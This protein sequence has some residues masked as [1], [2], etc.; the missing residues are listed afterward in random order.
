MKPRAKVRVP[1]RG[2]TGKSENDD[3]ASVWGILASSIREI[4][5]KNSSQ[6]SFEEL[7]RNAYKL[8]LRKQAM[9]LYEKVAD[10]EKDWLYNEVR[11]QV[12]ALITPAL[13]TITD[14]I[15]AT[16]HAN[17]RKAAGERL[18]TKLKEVWEDHQLCMGMITDVLMYMDRVVMQELRNQSI[19][20]TSMFLFRDCVLRADIGE[21]ANATIGSVF[22]NTMLFMILLEREGV[23]IDRALIKHC[24]YLL[25]GLYEDGMEDP[26][27]KLYH[28]TFE[29]AFLEASRK[30]YAAE[31]QRLLTTTDAATFCKRVT[32]RI[33]AE[34][35]LCRQTLSPVTEAKVMEVIDDCLIRHYI[36]EVIRMDDSGVKYMIQNDRLEDLRNVFELIARIDAKKAA[37]TRV[38]Q[39]TVVEYGTAINNAAKELSQNPPAPSTIEPGKK[40]S[41][42]EE[43]PPVLNVQTAAAIKWVDDV[44]KL[45]AKFDRIWEEAFVKDQ[46]LQTSLT[47]S[48]SDFINVNPRGTEYLSLFFDENLRK[49]IKGKTEEEVD[50][51]IENGITLLRYIRDK[52]L[53]ETY[54]KKHLSRRLLMKRSASMDAERQMIA[55]MKMEVG[56][57]F[58]QRLESMFK[59][60]AVSTDLTTNYR[61]YIAQ[62]GDPDIKR[63]ELEMSV[64]TSTMWPMEIMSSY[65]RDGQVQLPCIFPKNVESLK[66]SF[67]RFYLDKHSGRKLWWLPGMGTADIRATF[68][69]PNGKVERHDLNVS[70]YAMVILLL[71]NDMP[72]GESLTFE[73]IQEKTRIPTNELIRNLQSLAVA[74]KTRVLRKEP[75]SKG[76]QP[77]D[78]FSF[79]EQFTSKFT[80]LK[81]GVVSAGGNKVENK[82]ERTDTEKK[83]SEERGN[84]IE[85]AI[86]TENIGSFAVITEA[87]SQLAARF[88]PDVNMVK[89]RI[90][91]LIDR[92][93]LERIT[94]SDPPAYSYVA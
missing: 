85:A 32:G 60:M 53:F 38:V 50:T 34:Q 40:P 37:L 20:D 73:E 13:L 76:V 22:E 3:F 4:H 36:G 90:E 59:D 78:K 54:Y 33:K 44:L 49:G 77:S 45:K 18:L 1:R 55:K 42:A 35:S 61:D 72:S 27:G 80:R 70:T 57:T 58:T 26:S 67:E 75:M 46:A 94:D 23:I 48:F 82:E 86:T 30:Y 52:D 29:P 2:M 21:E 16:E 10:L 6:L 12:A 88:T 7:Y 17:E 62:Q 79:N 65:S 89:K 71:F 8:V 63:I 43:K 66:Q 64:L 25:D 91:S 92:E 51:L 15:D 14:S 93:Y 87:I 74:P 47:Y 24:V 41:A 11:K 56:N 31:G 19:Y 68:T 28:T 5:T 84:T 69:R 39:Q 9:D 81:I 83:T